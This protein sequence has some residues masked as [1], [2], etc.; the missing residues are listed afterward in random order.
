MRRSIFGRHLY[1]QIA[2]PLVLAALAVGIAATIVAVYFLSGLTDRWVDHTAEAATSHLEDSLITVSAE[3]LA[4]ARL[5]SNDQRLK[6]ALLEEDLGEAGG[7]LAQAGVILEADDVMLL[8]ESGLVVAAS[9]RA[10]V[11]PGDAVLGVDQ[12]SFADIN[13]ARPAILE[14]DGA[15]TLTVL[16][17]I[18][19]E[20]RVYTVAVSNQI[21]DSLLGTLA[22]SAGDAYC[23]YDEDTDQVACSLVPAE[24]DPEGHDLLRE[25]LEGPAPE[26]LAALDAAEGGEPGLATLNTGDGTYRV[27]VS[28]F[29]LDEGPLGEPA[30]YIVSVVSQSVTAAAERTTTQLII[31]W[32]LIAI[33]ALVGLGV[34]VARR[35]SRPLAELSEGAKRVAEGDFSTKIEV[36]GSNEIAD[37]GEAFNQMTES[38]K[39]RSESLTKKVLELATLYEMSRALGSTL[40]MN[41]LLENVL[42]SALR[43]FNLELGYVTVRDKDTGHLDLV[44]W[45][46]P[47]DDRPDEKALRSSMAEW[48][49]RE[50]RPLIFNPNEGPGES[51]IDGVS[52]ALAA[53]CVPL[54]AP[55]G[56]IGAISVGSHDPDFKFNS[57]DVRLLSTIANHVTIAIGNIE[58]FSSLQEAYLA[59]VRSLAAAVDAK[60]A[61]TRG[62]SDKVAAYAIMIGEGLGLSHEQRIALE[63]AAY[64][65]DIGKI[66]IKEEI[67]L[68]PGTLTDAE[69]AQMSH[70][71]LIG[72]NILRPVGFPWPITPIVRHHHERWDGDGYPAGLKG[73]EI[74][75]LA[76]VLTVADAFEAMTSDRPYRSAR[77][78]EEGLAE[79]ARCSGSQFDPRVV[80]V[81]EDVMQASPTFDENVD[82]AELEDVDPEEAQAIFVAVAEGM[83]DSF[84]K[85]GG[86][87]LAANVERELSEACRRAGIPVSVAAGRVDS[88][89]DDIEERETQL[90]V[91]RETLRIFDETMGKM[92]GTTLV[93]HFYTDALSAL[94]G[95]MQ[96]IAAGL[97]FHLQ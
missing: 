94:S 76:R 21:T 55:E 52:G 73:E 74:P 61:F 85:L 25:A 40:E 12:R 96:R 10:D 78:L 20:D 33:L 67:L 42:D 51:Q 23:F 83:L 69:M 89:I 9:G 97:D 47:G 82:I 79:L 90:V 65:H 80:Q 95:R 32:S 1:N 16:E 81:F 5:V 75:L 4:S 6:A 39:E 45:R 49:I 92:S 48:V 62:H 53:L 30:G 28:E 34:W 41:V 15:H 44:A 63:M 29:Y 86:P 19:V 14:L 35:V 56:S 38:L 54:T 2:V 50:G 87:R 17:P 77:S 31:M 24:A 26:V 27:W 37:L 43:I 36:S 60:D 64:L 7:I 88:H 59:T 71:P 70:H 11:E 8:D 22:G 3:M 58:L 18:A 72:A 84:R 13:M 93:D 57:D 66:G 91:M 46:A 68:K